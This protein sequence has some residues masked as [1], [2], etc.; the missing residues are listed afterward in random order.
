M[1]TLATALCP[2]NKLKLVFEQNE[3]NQEVNLFL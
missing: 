1:I 2:K 3:N